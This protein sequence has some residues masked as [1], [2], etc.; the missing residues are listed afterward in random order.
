MIAIIMLHKTLRVV[1]VQ[2]PQM[3]EIPRLRYGVVYRQCRK[4]ANSSANEDQYC[5]CFHASSSS[6]VRAAFSARLQSLFIL[7]SQVFITL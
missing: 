6:C 2:E 5:F 7:V 4:S 3:T 1:V